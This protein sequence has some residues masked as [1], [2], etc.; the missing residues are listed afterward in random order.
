MF[1]LLIESGF[2]DPGEYHFYERELTEVLSALSANSSRLLTFWAD[3]CLTVD[4]DKS[5][6]PNTKQQD[7]TSLML[8]A[9][10]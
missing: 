9:K 1:V 2:F 10:L 7:M 6:V 4:I 3:R 5:G 8:A